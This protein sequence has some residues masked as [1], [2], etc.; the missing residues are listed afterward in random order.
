MNCSLPL[1]VVC[2]ELD[3]KIFCF[4]N[5]FNLSV[6]DILLFS[7]VFN[8]FHFILFAGLHAQR[9]RPRQDQIFGLRRVIM[10]E[11]YGQLN[12]DVALLRLNRPIQ[13]GYMAKPVCL[14]QQNSRAP[15]GSRCY[16]TGTLT[17]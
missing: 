5:P 10:H 14:P 3:L 12:F 6:E 2:A 9:E 15:A 16:I 8:R 7:M 13:M 11:R 4:D 17:L 1:T